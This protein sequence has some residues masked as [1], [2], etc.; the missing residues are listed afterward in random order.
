MEKFAKV[1][2][3]FVRYLQEK[4]FSRKE[5]YLAKENTI[6]FAVTVAVTSIRALVCVL[7]VVINKMNRTTSGFVY[8]KEKIC[9]A[10]N[11]SIL[12]KYTVP[13]C[14]FFAVMFL[15]G[16]EAQPSWQSGS[17]KGRQRRR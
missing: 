2:E 12:I 7:A 15:F 6:R 17:L 9:G 8:I 5:S 16:W 1:L 4:P 3:D 10:E 11:E 14:C 13:A